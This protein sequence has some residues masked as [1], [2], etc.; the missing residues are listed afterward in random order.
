MTR[1][2]WSLK[3][4][5]VSDT[6]KNL[7]SASKFL[8]GKVLLSG[9]CGRGQTKAKDVMEDVAIT[10]SHLLAIYKAVHSLDTDKEGENAGK[11]PRYA[12]ILE[13]DVQFPFDI[14]FGELIKGAP[15]DFGILE[16]TSTD[17]VTM[18]RRWN[19]YKYDQTALWANRTRVDDA[20]GVSAYIIDKVSLRPYIDALVSQSP[21][22]FPVMLQSY[23]KAS[24]NQHILDFFEMK[25]IA[26]MR[27]HDTC[28]PEQ[29]C[30]ASEDV[31]TYSEALPCAVSHK[32]LAV[33]RFMNAVFGDATKVSNMP[34]VINGIDG[35]FN[36][37]YHARM[38]YW[39][40]SEKGLNEQ[41]RIVRDM[42][43]GDVA[44]PKYMQPSCDA[45]IPWLHDNQLNYQ[46]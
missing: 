7:Q 22:I 26:G 29:C 8:G 36:A 38:R 1:E 10:A 9:L 5:R 46:Y 19:H 35:F 12:L 42:I 28:V 4:E 40:G 25:V 6:V 13:D 14:D 21:G 16:L 11:T 31:I 17:S 20:W 18:S 3:N 34:L 37:S 24:D 23:K 15:K 33:D 39:P 32:G 2:G 41:R 44:L 27:I 43:S 45:P 30:T